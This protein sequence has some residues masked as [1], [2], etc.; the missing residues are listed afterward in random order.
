[1]FVDIFIRRPILATVLAL[2]IILAG[3]VGDPDAADCAVSGA[4]AAAGQ[5]HGDL[6]RRQRADRRVRGHHPDRA[7][8]QRRR[9]HAV[10]DLDQHE[11]R[12]QHGHGRRS[13]S[14]AT[15]ISR[16]LTCRTASRR[17][18]AACRTRSSNIGVSVTK[19]S[20]SFV[21]AAGVYA[22]DGQYDPLFISNYLDV[23][24]RDASSASRAWRRHHL[25]R[26]QLR[27][28]AVARSRRG[29]RRAASPPPK[30]SGRFASRTCRWRR[31]RSASRPCRRGRP[32][33]S[34]SAPSAGFRNPA[35]SRTSS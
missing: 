4:G 6:H 17:R 20:A 23:F 7:G 12:R 5:R 26:A 14:T 27:D 18:K 28:A 2:V 10:H 11:Q 21:L 19:A 1:M 13:T 32:I 29:W 9:G 24:V 33:R 31:A 25:R 8:H 3:A 16:P 22:E 34:A 35:S 15:T 30:S